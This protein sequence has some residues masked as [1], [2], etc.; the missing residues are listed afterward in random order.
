VRVSL[1]Y[2]DGCPNWQL[3]DDRLAEALGRVG[4]VDQ[5]VERRII[6][7][8]AQAQAARFRGSP[9]FL[10][11]GEDPFEDDGS[12]PFGLSCRVYRSDAGLAGSPTVD[13]LVAVLEA[14]ATR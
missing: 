11:D 8:D 4:R 9:T 5:H 3:A 7:T 14:A 2:V 10:V 13:D 1:L 6:A 12:G